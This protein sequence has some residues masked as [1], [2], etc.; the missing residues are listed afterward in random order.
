MAL[1]ALLLLP[2]TAAADVYARVTSKRVVLGNSL[3]ERTW[4]RD[5]FRTVRLVDKRD[6]G[7]SWSARSRD[8]T[9]FAG[10]VQIGSDQFRVSS[11]SV[12]RLAR[13]GLRVTMRLSG[14]PGLNA[15]RIAEAYP[16]VA[17]FRTQT[18]VQPAAGLALSGATLD[19]AAVGRAAPS[20]S[21]FHAGTDWRPPQGWEGPQIE[22]GTSNQ[23]DVR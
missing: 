11:A 3:A 19:E 14:P 22:V 6:G 4:S 17:G 13:G 16:G 9:M 23:G 2:G 8:F 1:L 7:R 10:P 12:T 5:S 21:A 20:I 15:T 18:I